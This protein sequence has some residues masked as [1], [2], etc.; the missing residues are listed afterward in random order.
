MLFVNVLATVLATADVEENAAAA[1]TFVASLI[2]ISHINFESSLKYLN[3]ERNVCYEDVSF[4]LNFHLLHKYQSI[5]I[6][7]LIFIN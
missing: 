1:A 6:L 7:Y 4:T 5:I 3:K 2:D